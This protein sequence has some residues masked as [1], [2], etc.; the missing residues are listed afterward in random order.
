MV[1]HEVDL[2]PVDFIPLGEGRAYVVA[3]RTIAVFRQRDGRLF[4]AD[5]KCPH[6]G[7]PLADGIAGAGKVICP[8]HAW[9]F[10]L[11]TGRCLGEEVRIRT[12]PVREVNGHIVVEI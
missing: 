4:A 3:G 1:S 5:N 11:A 6:R 2:G 8:L 10:D 7:G 9:K 12:Y